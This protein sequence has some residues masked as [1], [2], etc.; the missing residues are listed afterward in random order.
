MYLKK[1][2]KSKFLRVMCNNCSNTQVIFG[3]SSMNVN[4]LSCGKRILKSTGGKSVI[5][6]K[7]LGVLG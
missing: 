5:D 6:A 3:K 1:L 4:C 7:V 2:P